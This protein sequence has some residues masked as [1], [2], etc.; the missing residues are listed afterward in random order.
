[1]DYE[2]K[3]KLDSRGRPTVCMVTGEGMRPA[4]PDYYF[5]HSNETTIANLKD[6]IDGYIFSTVCVG[7]FESASTGSGDGAAT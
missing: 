2:A 5:G 4:V 1:M 7:M 3:L 6:W